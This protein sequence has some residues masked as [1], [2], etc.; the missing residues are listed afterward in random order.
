MYITCSVV[1]VCLFFVFVVFCGGFLIFLNFFLNFFIFLY[2]HI[3]YL[4]YFL[5]LF[6]LCVCV[7]VCVLW[8][9]LCSVSLLLLSDFLSNLLY[10]VL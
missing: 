9:F 2:I 10:S 6:F 1:V 4:F 8:F 5:Y 3:L 7:C